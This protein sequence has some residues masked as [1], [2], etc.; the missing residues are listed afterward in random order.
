[1]EVSPFALVLTPLPLLALIAAIEGWLLRRAGRDHDWKA[2][3]ASLGDA[4]GRIAV[5]L[6]LKSGVVGVVLYAVW[7]W[8]V[9]TFTMDRWWHWALLFLGQEF[10]YYWMHRADHRVRWLWL[11]QSV[12]HSSN[13][14]TMSEAYRFG[15][16][17]T[18]TGATRTT[19][20]QFG[21]ALSFDGI[22]DRISIGDAASLDLTAGVTLEVR[23][24]LLG[25]AVSP[26]CV[27][28]HGHE[29]DVIEVAFEILAQAR[30]RSRPAGH[31]VL[32]HFARFLRDPGQGD[33][34]TRRFLLADDAFHVAEAGAHQQKGP[35][36]FQIGEGGIHAKESKAALL[37]AAE[38]LFG[39]K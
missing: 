17:G 33:A 10:C 34:R 16:T 3:W 18:I 27:L 1:M 23:G 13:P 26:A 39:K 15:W 12:H 4:A 22:N 14:Y 25:R 35:A 2:Y 37:S 8:R 30:E 21:R 31:D 24:Q 6:M 7:E 20:G 38:A 29:D 36:L 11:N 28:A 32:R 5:N 9:A 19:A